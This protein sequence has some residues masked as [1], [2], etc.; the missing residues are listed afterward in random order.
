MHNV[1][2]NT[3]KFILSILLLTS[4]SCKKH[5]DKM[6]PY[7]Q[8]DFTI[9][10]WST[11]YN[12][13]NS[14]GGYVYLTGGFKGILIYRLN[15]DEFLAYDRCCSYNPPDPCERIEMEPSGLSMIDSCCGSRFLILDGSPIQGPATKPLRPYMTFFDGRYLRVYN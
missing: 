15:M 2:R 3:L 13:L 14:V 10:I 1:V 6:I 7:V 4:P 8:V 11:F 5:D 9:D 12:E